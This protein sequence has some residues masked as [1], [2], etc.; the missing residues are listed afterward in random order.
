MTFI[1][2]TAK[3]LWSTRK[4]GTCECQV[5]FKLQYIKINYCISYSNCISH[6]ECDIIVITQV[7]G[8]AKIEY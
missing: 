7:Q 8:E 4:L 5:K 3:K 1:S 6:Y 2:K